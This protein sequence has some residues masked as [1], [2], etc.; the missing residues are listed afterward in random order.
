MQL[1]E[2]SRR[3]KQ[4][5]IENQQYDFKRL[6]YGISIGPTAFSVFTIKFF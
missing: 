3:L 5:V 4:F 2:Q 6:L 1:D